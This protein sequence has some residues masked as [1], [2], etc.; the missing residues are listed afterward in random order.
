M[1]HSGKC[2]CANVEF[3]FTGDPIGSA[4]CYCQ[5]CQFRTN[6]DRYFGVWVP[7]ENLTFT[8]GKPSSF[9]RTGDSGKSVEHLFCGNCGVALAGF[10]EIGGFYSMAASTIEN[11]EQFSPQ[12]LIYTAFAPEGTIF[13]DGVPRYDKLPPGMGED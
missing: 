8:R 9:I 10:A 7:K 12:M 1:T 5:S 2:A 6:S 4:Y 3:T 13:P 11:G